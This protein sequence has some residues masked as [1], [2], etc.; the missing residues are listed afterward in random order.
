MTEQTVTT[1]GLRARTRRL[2]GPVR[3]RLTMTATVLVL[4]ALLI[5]GAVM[6]LVT[7]NLL[8]NTADQATSSRAAEIATVVRSE[9]VDGV[10][11]ALLNLNQYV[12]I[13]QIYSRDGTVLA[14]TY[15]GTT[16]PLGPSVAPGAETV[17]DDTVPAPDTPE[18]R[19]SFVGVTSPD[20]GDVTIAVGTSEKQLHWLILVVALLCGLM[21]PIIGALIA[22]L[23]YYFVG[24]SL[25]P[26]E[27]IRRRVDEISVGDLHQRVP[28]PATRD[29][30]ATLA[31]TMNEM[32]DRLEEA[33][34]RELRFVG[35]ASHE[36]NSPLTTLVGLFDLAEMNGEGIDRETA[37][38][39]MA[40]EA[41][42]LQYMVADMLLLARADESGIPLRTG[43]VDLDDIVESEIRRLGAITDFEISATILPIQLTGD[44]EKLSRALRN[45]TDNAV[46]HARS[47]IAI[48]M[49][50][51]DSGVSITVSDD[52]PGVSDDDKERIVDRFVRLDSARTRTF[53]GAGLGLAIVAEI[54]RA[55]GGEM[56]V[57][58]APGG[59]A[60]IGFELPVEAP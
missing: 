54:V 37:R 15:H 48:D 41:R 28:V 27:A 49:A 45:L 22:V 50:A 51:D 31:V 43:S 25:E 3:T 58:D 56:I 24:R 59:G 60:R 55:H 42:R 1:G 38:D 13:V 11:K 9:G 53:G 10:D 2:T 6:V 40:P 17:V 44:E 16:Q 20:H 23:T 46:R 52:G 26:V 19:T 33:R 29:E 36:L 18:F 12:D 14:S 35:D 30:I 39:V 7:R 57:D 21:F 4:V 47:R 8:Y 32:L 5:A 34:A